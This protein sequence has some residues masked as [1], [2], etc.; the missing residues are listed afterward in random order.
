MNS[1]CEARFIN[2][3]VT[4]ESIQDQYSVDVPYFDEMITLEIPEFLFKSSKGSNVT[5][6]TKIIILHYINAAG[7]SLPG[8]DKISY[9]DIPGL[10]GYLP[11][12]EQ[13]VARPLI[14]AF[15]FDKY[16]FLETGESLGGIKED[17]G[18]ASFTLYAL[19]RIPITFILWEGDEEFQPSLKMLFDPSITGYLPLED[20]TVI[21]KLASTRIIKEARLRHCRV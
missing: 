7:G 15:G 9:G 4:Y 16:V 2:A 5:L 10:A 19:P 6:V 12:F 3:G 13:R 18:D 14:T 20:I 21:S 8:V 17:Y 1:N 11:V